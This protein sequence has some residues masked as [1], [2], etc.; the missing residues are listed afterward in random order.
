MR[1]VGIS[2]KLEKISKMKD[3]EKLQKWM[4]SIK[5]HI[6]WTAAS[7]TF[8]PERVA[9]WSSI[10]NH[11]QDIRIHITTQ[12]GMTTLILRPRKPQHQLTKLR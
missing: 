6:Y 3:C 7:S 8:G 4:R 10:L 11:V 12:A 1:I 9:K 5:N 2:K